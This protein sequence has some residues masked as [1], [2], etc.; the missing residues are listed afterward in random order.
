MQTCFCG[1]F[2]LQDFLH[3]PITSGTG[4]ITNT[5]IVFLADRRDL[6]LMDI[7]WEKQ[8][9]KHP[10][11]CKWVVDKAAAVCKGM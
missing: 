3:T 7:W 8:G 10:A 5:S 11:M 4:S 1:C 9:L 2:L 6:H